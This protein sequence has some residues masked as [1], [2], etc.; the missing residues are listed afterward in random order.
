MFLAA[1][2]EIQ[3]ELHLVVAFRTPAVSILVMTLYTVLVYSCDQPAQRH[4][5]QLAWWTQ[6]CTALIYTVLVL[7]GGGG[8]G[9]MVVIEVHG[10][11]SIVD[12]WKN[13]TSTS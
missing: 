9:C 1:L 6:P 10:V 3:H 2:P 5:L 13:A 12:G 4:V 11:F 8:D 7:G